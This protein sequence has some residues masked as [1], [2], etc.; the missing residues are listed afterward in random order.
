M[1]RKV[2]GEQL[3]YLVAIILS[4]LVVGYFF[5]YKLKVADDNFTEYKLAISCPSEDNCRKKYE[6]TIL[7]SHT[8]QVFISGVKYYGGSGPSFRD[9]TYIFSILSPLGK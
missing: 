2:A 6:A 7:E 4:S 9:T 1:G 8:R 3:F 5:Y